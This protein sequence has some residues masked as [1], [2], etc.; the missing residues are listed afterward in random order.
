MH[1]DDT[2]RY[3]NFSPPKP[4]TVEEAVRQIMIMWGLP[5][6]IRLEALGLLIDGK[7]PQRVVD[8]CRDISNG[9]AN[10]TALGKE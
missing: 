7:N 10:L 9:I 2:R 6:D 3:F 8:S 5:R 1:P 4:M